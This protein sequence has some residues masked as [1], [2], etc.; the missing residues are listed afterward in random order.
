[1]SMQQ[2]L[3]LNIMDVLDIKATALEFLFE[4][5]F[6][7]GWGLDSEA[8]IKENK[9][10]K[11][12]QILKWLSAERLKMMEKTRYASSNEFLEHF[13]KDRQGALERLFCEYF[14][15]GKMQRVPNDLERLY[16]IHMNDPSARF[17]KATSMM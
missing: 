8:L 13:E 15:E 2:Q 16:Q 11:P 9:G 12:M 4:I 7:I 1:M 14:N 10:K 3:A 17:M 5:A 6:M